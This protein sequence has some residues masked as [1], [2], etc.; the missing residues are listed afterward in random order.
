[1][2]KCGEEG[3]WRPS[4]EAE[5]SA[6][7]WGCPGPADG[8]EGVPSRG[9]RW[10]EGGTGQLEA[11]RAGAAFARDALTSTKGCHSQDASA[12]W[13]GGGPDAGVLPP[14]APLSPSAPGA[15]QEQGPR[16][17]GQCRQADSHP[18]LSLV[19]LGLARSDS[20]LKGTAHSGWSSEAA[21]CPWGGALLRQVKGE[22][23]PR[24]QMDTR[25]PSCGL[26]APSWSGWAG[27]GPSWLQRAAHHKPGLKLNCRV[28][29]RPG[30]PGQ[31]GSARCR[32][33]IPGTVS[34]EATRPSWPISL[35]EH[36][37]WWYSSAPLGRLVGR[38]WGA[39]CGPELWGS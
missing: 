27:W 34:R 25:G 3:P 21:G 30:G 26:S 6:S 32:E 39:A 8:Q 5:L 12:G 37:V 17:Q 1:M 28:L 14:L 7:C 20:D 16:P 19:E 35:L 29:G 10:A 22:E 24:V 23:E 9:A 11:G 13:P 18:L 2:G 31:P 33:L 15:W 36:L 38:L 4:R